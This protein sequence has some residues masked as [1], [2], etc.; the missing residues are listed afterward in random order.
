MATASLSNP[1]MINALHALLTVA[2]GVLSGVALSLL[3]WVMPMIQ[4]ATDTKTRI[5][6]FNH[7]IHLGA[8]Y[9]LPTSRALPVLMLSLIYLSY[10]SAEPDI[11][12]R[13]K[14]Y[15]AAIVVLVPTGP[16]EITLIFPINDKVAAMGEE[17]AKMKM[18]SFGDQ[19]DR[20]VEE[21]FSKWSQWHIGRIVAPMVATGFFA[22]SAAGVLPF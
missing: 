21:M 20:E 12:A 18:D 14:H 13:W 9:L 15:I 2:L 3:L 16:W 1:V 8:T 6:Q 10:H 4:L 7:I 22:G 11:Q 19:R 17:L 5:K